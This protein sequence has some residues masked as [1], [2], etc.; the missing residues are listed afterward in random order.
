MLTNYVALN[1]LIRLIASFCFKKN[2]FD[3]FDNVIRSDTAM[4][5]SLFTL[6]RQSAVPV[7]VQ[8][9]KTAQDEKKLREKFRSTTRQRL[10]IERDTAHVH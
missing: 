9:A 10:S 3:E 7:H 1:S 2:C 8:T 5:A 6:L 4:M